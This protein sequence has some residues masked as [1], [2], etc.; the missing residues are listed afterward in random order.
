MQTTEHGWT[1]LD[2]VNGVLSHTYEFTP[3]ATANCFTARLRSGGL[4]VV[5]PPPKPSRALL[6][7]L[8]QYGPVEALFA[9]NGFHHLGIGPWR[10]E[11][12]KARGYAAPGA[13]TRINKRA[14]DAGEL[15]PLDELTPLLA[16]GVAVI[17]TP[18]SK[19]GETWARAQID[20]GHAWYASDLLANME[21]LPPNFILR[22]LFKWTKSA[23]GYRP[24][25]LAHKLVL[26]DR[27][28]TLRAMLED[29]RAH[30][31]AVMVPGHG[32]LLDASGIAADTEQLL[33]DAT[34]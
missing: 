30:P 12:P 9:P 25:N 24:F 31:P 16:E 27:K 13:I 26:R 29:V 2:G 15:S 8:A 7:E 5:S 34:R 1:I 33:E 28:A 4:L 18:S 6:D 19:C 3:G 21:S 32:G 23:P 17:E 20:G 22:L 10:R 11:F 14:R